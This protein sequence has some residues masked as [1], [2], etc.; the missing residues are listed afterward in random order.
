MTPWRFQNRPKSEAVD[1]GRARNPPGAVDPNGRC[2]AR[3]RPGGLGQ[4]RPSPHNGETS[5]EALAKG[6][7][8]WCRLEHRYARQR[9]GSIG[10]QGPAVFS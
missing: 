8:A 3:G 1:R 5:L 10:L 7:F 9:L 4:E 2:L 6:R